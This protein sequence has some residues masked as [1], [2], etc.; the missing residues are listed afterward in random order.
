[1]KLDELK[2][3]T[4]ADVARTLLDA[5]ERV[6]HGARAKLATAQ[7]PDPTQLLAVNTNLYVHG[8]TPAI[9]RFQTGLSEARKISNV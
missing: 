8:Q 3:A 7:A 2:R 4:V 9:T 6:A 1:M 5:L